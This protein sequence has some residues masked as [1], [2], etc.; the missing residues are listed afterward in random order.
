MRK[1]EIDKDDIEMSGNLEE[2]PNDDEKEFEDGNKSKGVRSG[3]QS[4]VVT[5]N[6]SQSKEEEVDEDSWDA[7][8]DDD[9]ECLDPTAME[10]V[11]K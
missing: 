2:Q 4:D 3:D 6:S 9:G 7:M 8:F 5:N 1:Q 10:E 11:Y